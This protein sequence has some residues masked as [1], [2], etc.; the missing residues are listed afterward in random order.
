MVLSYYLDIYQEFNQY[1]NNYLSGSK[2][3]CGDKGLI[4]RQEA[5]IVQY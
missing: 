2:L 3:V 5:E 1:A 4:F